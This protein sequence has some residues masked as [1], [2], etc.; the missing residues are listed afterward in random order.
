MIDASDGGGG[1]GGGGGADPPGGGGELPPLLP[2][3]GTAS[4]AS[5]VTPTAT[6]TTT[7]T[8]AAAT[9]SNRHHPVGGGGGGMGTSGCG[10]ACRATSASGACGTPGG[11]A[12]AAGSTSPALCSTVTASGDERATCG[13]GVAPSAACSRGAGGSLPPA[14]WSGATS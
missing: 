4:G 9:T 10:R 14:S 11:L 13:G 8:T 1:G 7:T 6:T 3:P 12:I 2:R 5:L